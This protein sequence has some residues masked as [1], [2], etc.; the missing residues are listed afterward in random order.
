MFIKLNSHTLVLNDGGKVKD[1]SPTHKLAA[2]HVFAYK[3]DEVDGASIGNEI[4]LD[5]F[6]IRFAQAMEDVQQAFVGYEQVSSGMSVAL[7]SGED[8]FMI[9]PPGTGKTQYSRSV[10]QVAKN[11]RFSSI[12][13]HDELTYSEMIGGFDPEKAM[14]GKIERKLDY[15]GSSHIVLLDEIWKAP[16]SVTNKLLD[17]LESKQ[18]EGRKIELLSTISASNELPEDRESSAMW[19]RLL[20]RFFM[21]ELDDDQFE[22]MLTIGAGSAFIDGLVDTEEIRLVSA[23]AEFMALNI[24]PEFAKAVRELRSS[25]KQSGITASN[26]RWRKIVKAACAKSIIDR[27]PLDI[28]H[29]IIAQDILWNDVDEIKDVRRVV[30]ASIDPLSNEV[31][32]I[33][34]LWEE[35]QAAFE[36]HDLKT[37]DE[38]QL[39]AM[40]QRSDIVFDRIRSIEDKAKNGNKTILEDIKNELT[41]LA[42]MVRRGR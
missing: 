14:N 42:K 23:V 17:I 13:F 21:P 16:P 40:K 31:Y 5:E 19:D 33:Q 3:N 2:G 8:I 36:S 1:A 39:L 9:S 25:A 24:S 10:S 30:R 38:N 28:S 7:L 35:Y 22:I 26:R 18:V 32:N 12:L 4:S 37:T 34:A 20:L 6:S 27:E 15:L 41:V 29:L 11:G